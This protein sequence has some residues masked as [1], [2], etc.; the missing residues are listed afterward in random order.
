ME[1]VTT[2]RRRKTSTAKT[3]VA[4][5]TTSMRYMSVEESRRLTLENVDRIYKENGLL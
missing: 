2:V 4:P 3:G 5:A 1:T